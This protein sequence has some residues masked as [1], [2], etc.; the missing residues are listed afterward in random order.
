MATLIVAKTQIFAAIYP[1]KRCAQTTQ[2]VARYSISIK[3]LLN[4]EK[5]KIVATLRLKCHYLRNSQ[6][7]LKKFIIAIKGLTLSP[8][9]MRGWTCRKKSLILAEIKKKSVNLPFLAPGAI[10]GIHKGPFLSNKACICFT[11][12]V[13]WAGFSSFSGFISGSGLDNSGFSLS[14][15]IKL[16]FDRDV[17]LSYDLGFE[18]LFFGYARK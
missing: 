15:S 8:H 7:F 10:I 1:I 11:D 3:V 12:L 14:L 2:I 5:S 13:L 4:S 16:P 18:K 9:I 6:Y 17:S